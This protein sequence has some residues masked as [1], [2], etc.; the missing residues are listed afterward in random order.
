MAAWL[1]AGNRQCGHFLNPDMARAVPAAHNEVNAMTEN[2]SRL[3]L[4]YRGQE[5]E[6]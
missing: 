3:D 1:V 4:H 5:P 6:K 2:R